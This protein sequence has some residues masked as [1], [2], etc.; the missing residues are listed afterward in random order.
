MKRS[1]IRY[2]GEEYVIG[3][4]ADDVTRAIDAILAA[5]GGWYEVGF[6][7]GELRPTQLLITPGVPLAI[8]DANDPDD[9]GSGSTSG[10][11]EARQPRTLGESPGGVEV[12]DPSDAIG[13]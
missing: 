4:P 7:R 11:S 10:Q 9:A 6:G 2:G 8:I 5:G 1:L 3:E 12:E 13:W